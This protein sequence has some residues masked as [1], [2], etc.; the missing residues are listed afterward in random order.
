MELSPR[1]QLAR[2]FVT[3]R[4]SQ[5]FLRMIPEKDIDPIAS[6]PLS[7]QMFSVVYFIGYWY[8]VLHTLALH[9]PGS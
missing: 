3:S 1:L 2:R 8:V 6:S 4:F 5:A 9:A 7:A